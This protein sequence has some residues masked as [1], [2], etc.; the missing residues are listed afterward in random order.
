MLKDIQCG[1]QDFSGF[2]VLH[3]CS[4]LD[5]LTTRGVKQVYIFSEPGQEAAHGNQLLPIEEVSH[6]TRRRNTPRQQPPANPKQ[7]PVP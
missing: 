6:R 5:Y 4:S 2:Q 1:A 7:T 3:K